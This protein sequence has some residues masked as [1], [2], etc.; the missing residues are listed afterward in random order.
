MEL[1]KGKK[2]VITGGTSGIGRAIATLFV[3]EGADV[4]IIGTNEEKAKKALGEIEEKKIDESQRVFYKILDVSV[5]KDVEIVFKEILE[6]FKSIDILVNSAGITR[7]GFLIR[8]SEENWDRVMDVNLKSIF[9]T[10]KIVSRCMMKQ[11]SGKIINI[12]SVT[13]LIGNVGQVNY[14]ASKSG[15]IGFSK[16]LAKEVALKGVTVNSIAPGFIE[17]KMTESLKEEVK[18]ELLKSIPMKRFGKVED[19]ANVALFLASELA[20]YITGQCITVSGG[21]VM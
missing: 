7:D 1:L 19:V 21:M 15:M 8:M 4:V 3:K 10:C 13:G 17:T 18:K 9:N 6:E 2:A 5:A 12:S 11:K 16:S 14:A 20:D